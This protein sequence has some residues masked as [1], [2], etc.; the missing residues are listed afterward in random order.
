[1][2]VDSFDKASKESAR[3]LAW[4][5]LLSAA[6]IADTVPELMMVAQNAE[7]FASRLSLDDAG[8]LPFRPPGISKED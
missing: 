2:E 1:M 4:E 7:N 3:R 5:A 8:S 6:M